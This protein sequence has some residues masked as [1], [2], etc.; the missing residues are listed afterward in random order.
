MK[1]GT[2]LLSCGLVRLLSGRFFSDACEDFAELQVVVHKFIRTFYSSYLWLY[3]DGNDV[4]AAVFLCH[5]GKIIDENLSLFSREVADN[6][7][8]GVDV[9]VY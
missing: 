6:D 8:R 5:E 4:S 1:C 3:I 7:V 9:A 2:G